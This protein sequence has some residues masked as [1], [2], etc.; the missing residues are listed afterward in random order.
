M[1][2]PIFS[3][4]QSATYTAGGTLDRDLSEVITN[5]TP[6][7]TPFLS[8]M[9]VLEDAHE[10]KVGWHTDELRPA[11]KNKH[12]E[13]EDFKF[14]KAPGVGQ[15]FN[16]CQFFI[17]SAM[18]SEAMQKSWKTY[19]PKTDELG[20]I[21]TKKSKELAKDM[22]FALMTND[23]ANEENGSTLATMGGVPY[24]MKE[25][26]L[27]ATV[28]ATTNHTV[29]TTT[30]HRLETGRWVIFKATT[31]PTNITA[32]KRYYVRLDTTN[33]DTVFTIYESES[34]AIAGVNKIQFANAGTG[35]EVL[36]NNV[37]DGDGQKFTIDM[38]ND[39]MELAYNR[40]GNPSEL[41][42]SSASKRRFSELF[43]NY[44]TTNRDQNDKT[45]Y[46]VVDTFDTD[47][48]PIKTQIHRDISDNELYILDPSYWGL[49]YFDRPHMTGS[50]K[51]PKTG[52]YEKAVFQA[53]MTLQ[54]SQ[55]L[56]SV[57]I[58]NLARP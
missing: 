19:T 17:E 24:F 39:A 15:M 41:W 58:S 37:V 50:D 34:D 1:A 43:K 32:N 53:T 25:E 12:A 48:G 49:R 44:H 6:D 28:D 27:S 10:L 29:T 56:A 33:P 18:V 30:K 8:N 7:R 57:A 14:D 26:V 51:L 46:S 16:Y 9:P 11:K 5:I 2:V 42:L 3:D 40:G 13:I 38:L 55:P 20:R 4:S 21:V 47:F 45:V 22:E 23:E 54:A 52:T 35:V 36:I 31:L